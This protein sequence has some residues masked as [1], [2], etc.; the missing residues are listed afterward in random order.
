EKCVVNILSSVNANPTVK[1][2]LNKGKQF[3]KPKGKL[4]DNRLNKTKRVWKET[5]KLFANIGYQW[6]PTGK[7]FA[8]GE[9]F[10]LTKLSMKCRTGHLL[11]SGLRLFKTYDGESF[12]AHKFP[13]KCDLKSILRREGLGYNLFSVGQFSDSD[14][15]VAFR[16]H[17]CFVRDING[18]DILKGSR[19]TNLTPETLR[20]LQEGEDE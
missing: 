16:K 6:R 14:L 19:S 10:P 18:A 20:R 13:G 1:R 15:E 3:W 8:L 17:T 9:M 5:G 4:F 2:V 7:N 12:K 11:V